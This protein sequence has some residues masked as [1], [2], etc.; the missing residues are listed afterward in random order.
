MNLITNI[1]AIVSAISVFLGI[2]FKAG[3][4]EILEVVNPANLLQL[5]YVCLGF[6]ILSCLMEIRNK[7]KS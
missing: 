7:T 2:I 1:V 5:A 4:I 3:K 6:A